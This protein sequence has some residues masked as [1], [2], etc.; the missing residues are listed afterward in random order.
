MYIIVDKNGK[1]LLTSNSHISCNDLGHDYMLIYVD[2]KY[3]GLYTIQGGFWTNQK[4]YIA[5]V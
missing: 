2:D 5:E 3:G 4:S 1:V